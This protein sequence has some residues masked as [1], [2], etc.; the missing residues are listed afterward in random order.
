MVAHR[1]PADNLANIY[2]FLFLSVIPIT[3]TENHGWSEGNAG[4]PYIGL[5]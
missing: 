1:G 3:F 5:V 4:L 2:S